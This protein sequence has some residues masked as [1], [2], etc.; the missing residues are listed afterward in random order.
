MAKTT[1]PIGARLTI[2]GFGR[3]YKTINQ[4]STKLQ[5]ADTLHVKDVTACKNDMPIAAQRFITKNMICADTNED[6]GTAIASV[7]PGDS[8]G[9]AVYNGTLVG[10]TSFFE[11]KRIKYD[12]FMDVSIYRSWIEAHKNSASFQSVNSGLALTCAMFLT[13]W[14]GKHM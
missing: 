4:P 9:P 2:T 1:P 10:V 11:T 3:T 6:P 7:L 12:F 8:G 5:I 13:F 14:L